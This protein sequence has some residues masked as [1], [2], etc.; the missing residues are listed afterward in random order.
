MKK[1]LS[2][3][4][5]WVGFIAIASQI[6]FIREF[7]AS[8]SADELS[9]GLILA[10]WLVGGAIGAFLLGALTKKVKSGYFVFWLAQIAMVFLLP[11]GILM[12]RSARQLLG[13]NP[14]QIAP[15]HIVGWA[16]LVIMFP[17]CAVLSFIF[18]LS[19]K[20]YESRGKSGATSIGMVYALESF[21]SMAGGLLTSFFLIRFFSGFG[22][23]LG[24]SLLNALTA[25][26][27]ILSYKK[28]S[29]G[30][31]ILNALIILALMLSWISKSWDKLND[32]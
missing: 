9:I 30:L 7:L 14:G 17:I 32:Y 25:L 29:P 20:L 15:F 11:A 22:I 19:C 3:T 6:V 27:L 12:V 1:Q 10:S 21:G 26:F 4:I 2:L 24:L 23:I 31:I 8:F 16:S 5:I 18:S 13:I 28:P